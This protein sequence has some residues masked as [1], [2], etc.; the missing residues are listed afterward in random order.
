MSHNYNYYIKQLYCKPKLY[1][2]EF[3][4][5]KDDI[6]FWPKIVSLYHPRTMLEVGIGNGRLINL[7]HE[8]VEEYDGIDF[9]VEIINYCKKK[10]NYS[11]VHLYYQDLKRCKLNKTY[12]LIILPFNVINNFYS[13]HDLGKAF[14][15]IKKLSDENTIIVIDTIL[16]Q[17]KDLSDRKK[18]YHTN[19]FRFH[20]QRVDVYENKI[21]DS[22]N[23]TCVYEKK[24][25]INNK[26]IHKETL[27]NRI[28]FHQELL[29]ILN[30]YGFNVIKQ[31]GDYNFEPISN[32]SRKQI[33]I[34]RRK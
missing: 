27:P 15:N 2:C 30:H 25:I 18:F 24:Y 14:N 31:Y 33:I 13:T 7:L 16:P 26:I 32:K 29:M 5:Y 12:D 17:V 34:I 9:S 21:F 10:F 20:K 8:M 19:T 22:I 11:N 28:F 23:S 4:D 1:I 6:Y 3:T